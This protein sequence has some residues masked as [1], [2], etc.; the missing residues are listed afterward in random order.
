MTRD[1]FKTILQ[2]PTK[3]G[4]EHL[5]DL[6][7]LVDKYPYSSTFRLLYLKCLSNIDDLSY[8]SELQQTAIHVA[9]RSNMQKLM[10]LK[11]KE[12]TTAPLQTTEKEPENEKKEDNTAENKKVKSEA[13][14]EQAYTYDLL[15]EYGDKAETEAPIQMKFGNL[16]DQFLNEMQTKEQKQ[17]QAPQ[18][19]QPYPNEPRSPIRLQSKEEDKEEEPT[20]PNERHLPP[21][22]SFC[23]ETLAK[24]YIKQ[25]KF[26]KAIN[27]FKQLS[28]KYPEK[29]VYFAD[30]IRFLEKLIQNI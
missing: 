4:K 11:P 3:I 22:Q 20:E 12:D 9:D 26:E 18:H 5:P 15:K 21:T 10:A 1:E 27:I 19:N 7:N 30:Q 29:S 8:R 14:P 24:I 2:D 16:I 6:K 23:T 17:K 13:K 28:L 25:G